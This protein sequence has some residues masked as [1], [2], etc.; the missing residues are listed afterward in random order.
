MSGKLRR[1]LHRIRGPLLP[2]GD[3][4]TRAGA[5]LIACAACGNC[6][7]NP[8]NWHESD[9]SRWRVWLRCGECAWSREAIITEAEAKQLERDLEPGLREIATTAAKLDHERMEWEVEVFLAALRRDL[10]EPAD[11]ARDLRR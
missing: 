1:L 2:L 5:R 6:V 11:F 7:V 4:R 8:V 3:A 9:A 10:I